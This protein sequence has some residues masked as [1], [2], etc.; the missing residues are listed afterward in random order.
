[1]DAA[2]STTVPGTTSQPDRLRP[3]LI[4]FDFDGTLANSLHLGVEIMNALAP[5]FGHLKV[6]PERMMYLRDQGPRRIMK[7]LKVSRWKLPFLLKRARQEYGKRITEVTPY[8]GAV[9]TLKVLRDR[10]YRLAVLTS[11]AEENVKR[12][13]D[14]FDFGEFDFIEGKSSVWGKKKDLRRILKVQK[15]DAHEVVYI[16]DERRDIEA[17]HAN[18][19]PVVSVTWGFNSERGLAE[20]KPR[21]MVH[22]WQEME[23]V[24][25]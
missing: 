21:A 15:L 14:K 10:G 17:A 22:S 25:V 8:D 12:F 5:E 4:I 18:K 7:A 20:L 2:E 6:E 11:N 3:E 24:F 13:F 23:G 19:I 9:E 16:G 1:M